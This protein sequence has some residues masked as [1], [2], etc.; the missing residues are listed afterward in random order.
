MTVPFYEINFP[1][2]KTQTFN[3]LML[4]KYTRVKNYKI[5]IQVLFEIIKNLITKH[6]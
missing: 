2:L 1:W 5:I 6:F 3:H 4:S